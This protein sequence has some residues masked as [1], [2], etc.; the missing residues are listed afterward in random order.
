VNAKRDASDNVICFPHQ[1]AMCSPVL[2]TVDRLEVCGAQSVCV[3]KAI[4]G[5]MT[6]RAH[7]L[8]G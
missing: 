1:P 2:P 5:L 8:I 6:Y 7:H 3:E 4:L